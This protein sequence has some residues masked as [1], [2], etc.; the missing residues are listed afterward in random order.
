MAPRDT[1]QQ[2]FEIINCLFDPTPE[3]TQF[4][5]S[6]DIE[7]DSPGGNDD[8]FDPVVIADHLREIGDQLD[9]QVRHQ[10]ISILKNAARNQVESAFKTAVDSLCKTWM[11]HSGEVATERYLLRASVALGLYVQRSCPDMVSTIQG[12][13]ANYINTY[14]TPWIDQQGGWGRVATEI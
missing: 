3:S 5:T 12:V 4:K 11:P 6:Q 7:S 14:V 10:F 1:Q 13:M 2:T 9:E 8:S